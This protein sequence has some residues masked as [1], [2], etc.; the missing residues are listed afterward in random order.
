MN[1]PPGFEH[2]GQGQAA[3]SDL[4]TDR[5]ARWSMILG[6]LSVLL[7]IF[8]GVPAIVLGLMARKSLA[9]RQKGGMDWYRG[10][11]LN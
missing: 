3:P 2:G 9:Q 4:K 5:Y 11:L 6:L 1:I 7:C 8:S 10:W